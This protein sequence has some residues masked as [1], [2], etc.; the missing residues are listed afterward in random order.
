MMIQIAGDFKRWEIGRFIYAH[1]YS[2]S[3]RDGAHTS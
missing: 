2:H 3:G 1:N